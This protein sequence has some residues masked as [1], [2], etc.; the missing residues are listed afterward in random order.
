MYQAGCRIKSG[1]T[2]YVFGCRSNRIGPRMERHSCPAE[3]VG[4]LPM[5]DFHKS[6][7]APMTGFLSART[8]T[9]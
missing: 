5:N 8:V 3:R 4:V 9:R 6:P 1:M 7:I 2:F